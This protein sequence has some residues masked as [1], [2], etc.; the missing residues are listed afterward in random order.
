MNKFIIKRTCA[1]TVAFLI[2]IL[3]CLRNDHILHFKNYTMMFLK[4]LVNIQKNYFSVS[5]TVINYV[6]KKL[7]Q[8]SYVYKL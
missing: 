8:K 4:F 7:R 6:T 1:N 2:S 3:G 5:S